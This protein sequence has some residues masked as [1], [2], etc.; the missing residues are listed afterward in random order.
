MYLLHSETKEDARTAAHKFSQ[1]PP[2]SAAAGALTGSITCRRADGLR[3]HAVHRRHA[4]DVCHLRG[5]VGRARLGPQV[6]AH[7]LRLLAAAMS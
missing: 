5:E 2:S 6:H 7:R 1:M 3:R 4:P